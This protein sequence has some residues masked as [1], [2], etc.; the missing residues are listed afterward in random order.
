V[1][2]EIVDGL[3]EGGLLASLVMTKRL[4]LLDFEAALNGLERVYGVNEGLG[5]GLHVHVAL[6]HGVDKTLLHHAHAL[7][8]CA[9]RLPPCLLE[10]LI[11]SGHD[12]LYLGELG[13]LLEEVVDLT[14]VGFITID[15]DLAV[16]GKGDI[17]QITLID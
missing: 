6:E 16:E 13:V 10:A 17:I 1:S 4:H 2:L 14:L 3:Q 7:L 8:G 9:T 15:W 11:G 12:L 5:V